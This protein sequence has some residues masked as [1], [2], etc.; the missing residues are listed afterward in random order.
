M[1]D[2]QA[3]NSPTSCKF[4]TGVVLRRTRS[5]YYVDLGPAESRL[6]RIRGNLFQD[7]A[8]E[9]RIAVGD[10][11]EVEPDAAEDAGWI[12]EVH[13]RHS[14][15]ARRSREGLPEQTLVANAEQ[16]LIVAA[17]KRPEFRHGVVDRLIVAGLDGG[18]TPV[19]VLNK[20]DLGE[21]QETATIR[22]L[23]TGLGYSV[24]LTSA[25]KPSGLET[26]HACLR[27]RTSVL[28]GHSG[29]GK[30]SL[31][32]ALYPDWEIRVGAVNQKRGKGR[33]TTTMAEMFRLPEGGYLVDTPGIRELEPL[34]VTRKTLDQHFVEFAPLWTQCRF[35]S[36][37]HRHEP[38]CAVQQ[39]VAEGAISAVR[40]RSYVAFW[41]SLES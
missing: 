38:D 20:T 3:S 11:V 19:L 41:E 4:S 30:S 22:K 23:Y 25:T 14:R 37:S 2:S 36:C 6:C 29:V 31:V 33:H 27:K 13:P 1:R 24:L 16:L 9:A 8:S 10:V 40:Y 34:G 15:L 32:K 17:L 21:T 12:C 26:L 28:A 7:N 39:G 5:F 18:L 35:A